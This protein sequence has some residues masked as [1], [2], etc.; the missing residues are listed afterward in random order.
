MKFI[1][2]LCLLFPRLVFSQDQEIKVLTHNIVFGG[3]TGG[4]GAIINKKEGDN[5]RKNFVRGFWQGSI[6]GLLNYSA[7]KTIYYIDQNKQTGYALPARLLSSAGNSI[8]QN[9]AANGPFLK[10]W[11]FEYGFLRFDYYAGAEKKFRVRVLP[12]SVIATAVALNKGRLD[13][14]TTL[15]TGVMVLKST[16]LI[17]TTRGSTDGINYGRAFIYIDDT[18]KYHLISHELIH[19]FQYRE[20]LVFNAYL[21]KEV[22]KIK[23]T[24]F[25]KILT[26]YI[27]PDIPYFGLFYLL[28]GNEPKPRYF[29]NYFEFE[30]ERFATNKHVQV[31]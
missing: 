22:S 6:G 14:N 27:Y 9:A 31:N 2:A 8:I 26:K 12:E 23:E 5:W 11:N 28:E 16:E 1:F 3:L 29:K 10:N 30:A 24:R 19:E 25:K 7:K 17:N 20:Y 15:L 4:V 13:V 18:L 21:K